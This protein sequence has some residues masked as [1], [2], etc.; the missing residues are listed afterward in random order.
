MYD[1]LAGLVKSQGKKLRGFSN[2]HTRGKIEQRLA[3]VVKNN[4]TTGHIM[5]V[6]GYKTVGYYTNNECIRTET[7][8]LVS[9]GYDGAAKGFMKL[10]DFSVID[11]AL[12]LT[13][14]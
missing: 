5:M 6:H 14:A 13:I 2:S 7:F 11:E 12:I 1:L 8:L 10:N 4:S 9:S 3:R